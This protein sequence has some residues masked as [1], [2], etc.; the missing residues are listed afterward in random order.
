MDFVARAGSIVD[1]WQRVA[2]ILLVICLVQAWIINSQMGTNA[3]LQ[4]EYQKIR[5]EAKVYVVPGSA[6][7]FYTP[8]KPEFLLQ[9]M[10]YLIL[11]SLNTYTYANLEEQYKEIRR[12][13]GESML[14][15]SEAHFSRLVN[16]A[17]DDERSALFIPITTSYSLEREETGV[18]GEEAL[19]VVKVEGTVRYI[20]SDAVVEAVPIEFTM[21]FKRRHIT[22]TNPFGF[23]LVNY[24][25]NELT[26]TD[27]LRNRTARTGA[28]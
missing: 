10:S 28:L 1:R 22:P 8:P 19:Y 6:A 12:F 13:F 17:F 3:A 15:Q 18:P 25:Q 24:R 7:G 5:D 26:G 9:E 11:H 20:I 27:I 16:E 4:L 23:I 21:K 14:A 2:G